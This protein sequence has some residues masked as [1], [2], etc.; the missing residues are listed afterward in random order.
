MNL[1]NQYYFCLPEKIFNMLPNLN[2]LVLVIVGFSMER[3]KYLI[4]A[5][6]TH[7]QEDHPGAYSVLK[8]EYLRNIVPYANEYLNFLKDLGIV[9]WLNYSAGRNSR[10]YR[11]TKYYDGKILYH[12]IT[13]RYL[14]RRIEQNINKIKFRNSKKY[15]LLNR[16]VYQVQ[17]DVP[18]ALN[19]IEK[20]YIKNI[21]SVYKEKKDKANA[22]RTFS[23]GEIFKIQSGQ[24]YIKVNSTNGR[25]DSNY[26]RLPSELVPHL[27]INGKSLIE[28]DIKNSQPFFAVSLFNP[29]LEIQKIIGNRL[30]MLAKRLQLINKQNVKLYVSLVINGT[31]YDFMAEKFKLYGIPFAD[32]KDL[33]EQLFIVFFGKNNAIHFSPAVR[34]FAEIFPSVYKL[35]SEIKKNKHNRLAILLQR[36]ESYV[37][38]DCVVPKILNEFPGL[39]FIT[40]HDSLLPAGIMVTG[41]VDKIHVLIKNEIEKIIGFFPKIEIKDKKKENNLIN[42]R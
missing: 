2:A 18:A 34:L 5:I 13:D 10:L 9:E 11:I 8:M 14:I 35:F 21:N 16:Y 38:L 24:I 28:L 25:Y 27:S 22:R 37:M 32:R 42:Y 1:K 26:T 12:V 6:V 40:K 20:T 23:I 4:S 17:I 30:T 19:T 29:S 36:I 31:F 3:L 41:E 7:K 33:K 15:P 39:E